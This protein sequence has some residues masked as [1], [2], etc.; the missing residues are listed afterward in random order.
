MTVKP[1][2][3]PVFNYGHVIQTVTVLFAILGGIGYVARWQA[4]TD[5]SI[6]QLTASTK[7]LDEAV[8]PLLQSQAVQDE[9]ILRLTDVVVEQR[10][11]NASIIL[12]LGSIR[13]DF[14]AVK[15]RIR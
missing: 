15:A 7:A 10:K 5:T 9:R 1:R 6:L 4:T 11:T 14:A 3:E 13:E 12:Q 8:K 2:F